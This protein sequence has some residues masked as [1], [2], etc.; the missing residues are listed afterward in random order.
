MLRE[1]HQL[2][3]ISSRPTNGV[4]ERIDYRLPIRTFLCRERNE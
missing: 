3:A 2:E 4:S 1:Q